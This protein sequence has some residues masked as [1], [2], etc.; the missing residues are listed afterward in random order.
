M[1]L[2]D[3]GWDDVAVEAWVDACVNLGITTFDHADI[4]GDYRALEV[5]GRVLRRRPDLRRSIEVVSKAGIRLVSRR[6]P[7]NRLKSYD[8]SAQYLVDGVHAQL[9]ALN[10]QH[11]DVFLLH[12]PDPLLDADEVAAAFEQLRRSGAVRHFGVSNFSPAEFDLLASRTELVTN[13]VQHSLLRLEPLQDGTLVDLQRRR[14]RPMFWSPLAGG[15]LLRGDAQAARRTR[16]ALDDVARG[17]GCSAAAVAYAWLLR[18][19]GGAVPVVSTSRAAG[20]GDAVAALEID[21]DRQEWFALL[22]AASG[23]ELP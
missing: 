13:Q 19:P 14:L 22:A 3:W 10:V 1:R 15:E 11:L 20:L 5:F 17:R 16:L 18:E 21:L 7:D 2:L 4:Y 8:S 6:R 9:R 12:R 23:E